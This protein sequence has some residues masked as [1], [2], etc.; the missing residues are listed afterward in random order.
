MNHQSLTVKAEALYKAGELEEAA[1][2]YSSAIASN[3]RSYQLHIGLGKVLLKKGKLKEA[4]SEYKQAIDL[5]SDDPSLHYEIAKI[6]VNT[7]QHEN[8]EHHYRQAIHLDNSCFIY[9]KELGEF[10]TR[11]RRW[12]EAVDMFVAA[13]KVK[14]NRQD[15]LNFGSF[16]FQNFTKDQASELAKYFYKIIEIDPECY[17]AYKIL[18]KLLASSGKIEASVDYC[19]KG[20]YGQLYHYHRKSKFLQ[21]YPYE[22]GKPWNGNTSYGPNFIIIGPWKCATSSLYRYIAQHP[23][24]VPAYVKE[25]HF[26]NQNFDYGIDW[27]LAHFPP[28]PKGEVF[29]SGEATPS[30]LSNREA[31]SRVF[32]SFPNAKLITILRNPVDRTISHYNMALRYNL[33][34]GNILD[35]TQPII[36]RINSGLL[37]GKDISSMDTG[38]LG[39]S[40]YVSHIKRWLKFFPKTQLLVLKMEDLSFDIEKLMDSVFT[41]LNLPNFQEGKY[42][43]VNQGAYDPAENEVRELLSSFF[44]PFNQELEDFLDL[45]FNWD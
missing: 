6:L 18:S 8:A 21:K 11:S 31:P 16:L 13:L 43:T 22:V 30:Y 10:L 9:Y 40:L 26:F 20:Y 33:V 45:K 5:N 28:I 44:K 3:P 37:E 25:I 2:L 36:D 14:K 4:I 34:K 24:V 1:T 35:Y 32:Q 12:N 29:I 15:R 39:G 38:I 42:E 17:S 23:D 19:Q 41:F 27:Y 7:G